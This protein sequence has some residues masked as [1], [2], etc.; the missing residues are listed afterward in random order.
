MKLRT[1][2]LLSLMTVLAVMAVPAIYAVNRVRDV[3]HIALDLQREAAQSALAVGRLQ[4]GLARLDRYQRAF[5]ATGDPEL[6]RRAL[7][8]VRQLEILL[9]R[10]AL[11][12][13]RD[14]AE[15]GAFP[16]DSLR[17]V[18]AGI[19][20]L[21]AD[22]RRDEATAML[23]QDALPLIAR[24]EAAAAALAVSLD[25]GTAAQADR[26]DRLTAAALTAT[27]TA[28]VLAAIVALALTFLAAELLRQPLLRLSGSMA[29]VAKGRFDAPEDLPYDRDDEVGEL[30]R[31]FRSMAL[32]LADLDRMKAEFVGVASH[33]LKTP[34]SVICGY[35][36]ML[37][38]EM[39]GSGDRRHTELVHAM[40]NQARTL[41]TRVEQ[42]LEISRMQAAGLR[43]GLEEISVRH[44]TAGVEKAHAASAA[45]NRV[46]FSTAVADTAPSFL[47]ADPDCLQTE[48]L[49]NLLE[50]AFRFTPAGGRVHL[51]VSG[52]AGDICF[53]VRD[54]GLPVRPEDL[55][56]VF[57]RYYQGRA[58]GRAGSGLGLPI[59]RA[60][61]LAHGGDI[62]VESD[63]GE[64]IFRLIL[65][66]H[67]GVPHSRGAVL[68]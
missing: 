11:S 23:A 6:A 35:A 33:D 60:G 34:I 12:S 26:A 50:H 66:I 64:T 17:S 5:V 54:T 44:F 61:A 8:V 29:T 1:L 41:G 19:R 20:T 63:G 42:L 49:A 58:R 10:V 68:R 40:A 36:E 14:V 38:E 28:L 47:I 57:D 9:H 16:M 24:A 37:E 53:E 59:A 55:P 45:R 51:H 27:I 39:N 4:A 30:S 25:R 22:G 3:R 67:P 46:A 18:T 15:T 56:F 32:R 31:S 65:P 7:D 43:L 13:Y 48:I 52:E 62:E 21:M 2:I